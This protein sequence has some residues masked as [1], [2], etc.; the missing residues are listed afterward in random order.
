MISEESWSFEKEKEVLLLPFFQYIV[1]NKVEKE[2]ER[3]APKE[4][5]SDDPDNEEQ[6]KKYG[7]FKTTTITLME[8]PFQYLNVIRTIHQLS[9][10]LC[11]DNDYEFSILQ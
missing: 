3:K 11:A 10:I 9:V 4:F 1:M 2:E 7:I 8:L 6:K 5:D